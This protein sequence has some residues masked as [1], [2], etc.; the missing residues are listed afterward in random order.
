MACAGAK[1]KV[2]GATNSTQAARVRMGFLSPDVD[3]E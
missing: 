1:V 2:K 3:F